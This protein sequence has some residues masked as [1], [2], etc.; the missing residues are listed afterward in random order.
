MATEVRLP[1]LGQT[2]EEGTI[3][4]CNIAVGDEVKKGD[5][6]FEI[7]TDKATLEMESPAEGFV[8][9]I[10]AEVGQTLAVGEPLLILAGKDEEIPQSFINSLKAK[11]AAEVPSSQTAPPPAEVTEEK[12]RP[13]QPMG[14]IIASPRAKKLAKD[15]G[16]EL[17]P[18][19]GTGPGGKITED[20]VKNAAASAPARPAEVGQ[21]IE[22]KLGATIKINKLQKLTAERM[23][24]SKQQIPCFYLTVKTDVTDLVEL[25]TKL[26]STGDI[27]IA[28]NDFIIRAVAAG[29]EKYPLMAGQL[30]GDV[31]KIADTVNVGLAVSAPNGLI[32]PVVKNAQTKNIRQ[33]AA[34]TRVLIDKAQREKLLLTDLEGACITVSNLG[35]F[36][37]D[38][39]IPIV[40][41]G[42][43]SILGVGR[44]AEACLPQVK[45]IAIRKLM[46]MTLSV[47]H[48]VANG[49]YAAQFLDF[50]SKFLEDTSNFT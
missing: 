14:K 48:K 46:T 33:I 34:D 44:I 31:I 11:P 30:E 1:Q 38:S 40:I 25:R 24:K 20:D 39:F 45:D 26:N 12:A 43:C 8:N 41:P 47:D 13:A 28:Y 16:I 5:V 2:M 6:I 36:G 32:V 4:G 50:V 23:V 10:L 29:L 3:V 21:E 42:Q 15:L 18:L 17:A 37:I 9:H 49:A 22:P 7:E 35:G 27:K 19:T